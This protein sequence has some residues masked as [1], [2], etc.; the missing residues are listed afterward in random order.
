MVLFSVIAAGLVVAGGTLLQLQRA[1]RDAASL[2]DVRVDPAAY[3]VQAN[4]DVSRLA[5]LPAI[6]SDGLE[7]LSV[8]DEAA[9]ASLRQAIDD[10]VADLQTAL[11][12]AALPAVP[13]DTSG[14]KVPLPA[15]QPFSLPELPDSDLGL[16]LARLRD[17]S[18]SSSPVGPRAGT[19]LD[20]ALAQVEG[21]QSQIQGLLGGPLPVDLPVEGLPIGNPAVP[22]GGAPTQVGEASDAVDPD[23][24]GAASA[25]AH[26]QAAL[27]LA[28]QTYTSTRAD[29]EEL[30]DLYQQLVAKVED[31]LDALQEAEHDAESELTAELE[32]RLSAIDGQV[33]ALQ[34]EA[35][36]MVARHQEA[37]DEAREAL[38]GTIG[39]AGA[40]QAAAVRQAGAAL[41]A[42]LDEQATALRATAE[43]RRQDIAAITAAAT[44]EL[45]DGAESTQ[46][47]QAIQSAAS[48]ADLKVQRDLTARLA[49][50][51]AQASAAQQAVERSQAD[52]AVLVGQA[53]DGAN[54]TLTQAVATDDDVQE[55]L[56]SVATT[57]GELISARESSL[58]ADALQELQDTASERASE[59]VAT[60]LKGTH[61]SQAVLGQVDDVVGGAEDTLV[62]EVGKDVDYVAKVGKDYGRVPTDER[63]ARAAHWS[64][65]ATGLEGMLQGVVLDGRAI[66][67][68]ANQVLAAA[69]Q[70]E[71]ELDAM[72]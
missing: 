35:D 31:A 21:L 43:Q 11:D 68:L 32:S 14:L 19:P 13:D 23:E 6:P 24:D 49:A 29:L 60:A 30:L 54:V 71:A 27:G 47:L 38:A 51:E 42:S 37:V 56:H 16:V 2:Q 28:S 59:V 36:R 67:T 44:L 70:A 8:V 20:D 5:E 62:G 50:I 52:L 72:G 55:Y 10:A 4:A 17:V 25:S 1:D 15:A 48:V 66:E 69:G 7:Q 34:A 18:V 40:T 33:S 64:G 9:L 45:G 26:A 58:A 65:E 46:A 63:K 3:A 12:D 39:Q 57:Y 61:A 41:Q 53:M 22:P